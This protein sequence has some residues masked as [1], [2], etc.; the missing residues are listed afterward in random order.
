MVSHGTPLHL[1]A[2]YFLSEMRMLSFYISITKE[3]TK[4]G[5]R[6]F[7]LC[8]D[9]DHCLIHENGSVLLMPI[10]CLKQSPNWDQL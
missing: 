1:Q 9:V 8:G 10:P 4:F 2:P 3:S 6:Y 7:E 5:Q